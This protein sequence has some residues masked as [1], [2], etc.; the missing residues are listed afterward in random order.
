MESLQELKVLFFFF[1][2]SKARKKNKKKLILKEEVSASANIIQP[3]RSIKVLEKERKLNIASS[4][5][6]ERINNYVVLSSNEVEV[7]MV[8]MAQQMLQ[9]GEFR[10]NMPGNTSIVIL[11][12][13]GDAWTI[14]EGTIR[15]PVMVF[16]EMESKIDSGQFSHCET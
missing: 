15:L 11:Q 14:T 3:T 2:Q 13:I 7:Q 12:Q 8:E 9:G 6:C 1:K 16:A 10:V 5:I 4:K